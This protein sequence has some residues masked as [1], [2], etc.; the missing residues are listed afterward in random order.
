[1]KNIY[2]VIGLMSGTSM[3]GLD[4]ACVRF[5]STPTGWTYSLEKTEVIKYSAAWLRKLEEAAKYNAVQW[6]SLDVEYG[7]YLGQV[8]KD[9]IR[10]HNLIVD[11]ISSHGHTIFHQPSKGF[12]AQLGNGNALHASAGIPVVN[13]FRS[14]D[15]MRGGEGA[16]LVPIG[17]KLLFNDYDVCL[18]FGGI[19][20]L[21][22]ELNEKRIAYDLCFC[23]MP[24]NYLIQKTGKKFDRNGA[25][26][27]S[28]VVSTPMLKQLDKINIGLRKK[29]PSL[30]REF[31]EKSVRPILDQK[32]IP[33][34]DKL[35]TSVE[36]TAKEIAWTLREHGPV[37]VLCTGGGVY[38]SFLMSRILDH[39]GDDVNLIVPDDE[40]V[41]FKE[42]LVFAFL[43]AL[44][45][46]NK[47]N[48]LK[49]VTH[50]SMD[51]SSG[52]MIGF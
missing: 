40:I 30:G 12:T 3:D 43:G 1:M 48:C 44:R 20:N 23:N 33:L 28:G 13:D 51:S 49:S 46:E 35:C 47:V 29:R 52:V 26:A 31:F 6:V 37:S 32:K 14:L 4:V 8:C 16:P 45:V 7:H 42:A 15:V 5:E 21:S 18:N 39:G 34:E 36:A 2:K 38:N 9:F 22:R 17:D 50:A 24:L 25:L 10:R 19:A 41:K 11:F 27:A